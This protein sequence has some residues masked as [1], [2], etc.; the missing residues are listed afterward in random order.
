MIKQGVYRCVQKR[1]VP[2]DK[3]LVGYKWVF[4]L[5]RDGTYKARLVAKGYTQI[6]GVDF[7]DN[8]A[9][10]VNDTVYRILN[11][12]QTLEGYK[13][14]LLDVET[15][16][17]H[18]ELEH[19]VYMKIPAGFTEI[20]ENKREL[21]FLLESDDLIGFEEHT[22]L[23][24]GKCIYGLVQS[25][26]QWW[27]KFVK[28]L[29]ELNFRTTDV[30]PCLIYRNDESGT[31]M[32]TIYVDDCLIIGTDQSIRKAVEE[33]KSRFNVKTQDAADD[34]LGCRLVEAKE[35]IYKITQPHLYDK[36]ADKF[37]GLICKKKYRTP[38]T[39]GF[40]VVRP[41]PEDSNINEEEQSKYKSGV[42]MLLYLVKHSRP[43]L[44]NAT[45]ELSKVMDRATIGQYKE[46]MRVLTWTV[47]TKN[48]GLKIAPYRNKGNKYIVYGNTDA[49]FAGDVET[50][51]SVMGIQIF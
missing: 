3:R 46:L 15:A 23:K 10:V 11:T 25:A 39:P 50:R 35:N 6:P 20:E 44:A 5:K 42:G 41:E 4:K 31:V 40:K 27:K 30:D 33:I 45:R 43:E 18:G 9:P 1:D 8:F 32:M 28:V 14:I 19:E 26:R 49:E 24:L 51:R 37:R 2:S 36:I 34:Y 16:F 47:D 17:L 12:V 22:C 48:A 29:T 38:S 21:K 7:S 13:S